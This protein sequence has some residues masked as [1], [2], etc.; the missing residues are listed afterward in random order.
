ML[1]T[2][3][4]AAALVLA[5]LLAVPLTGFSRADPEPTCTRDET[6][7]RCLVEAPPATTRTDP[8]QQVA[9]GGGPSGGSSA[10]QPCV[11]FMGEVKPCTDGDSWWSNELNCYISESTHDYPRSH[12]LWEG[13]TTGAIYDCYNPDIVSG[14]RMGTFWSQDPPAGPAAAPNPETLA[15]QALAAMNLRAP[16]IGIAP[17]DE[18]GSVGLVGLPVWMWVADPGDRTWGPTTASASAGG[19]TVTATATVGKV[20]W[21]MG[22]GTKVTC[23]TKG[24]AYTTSLGVRS[25]P[26]CGHQYSAMG[27]YTVT[28]TAYW[29]V[30][31]SGM[32]R[33]GEIA[34]DLE[35]STTVQIGE[36]QAVKN[37]Q[38]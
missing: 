10:P 15:R 35:R 28:A 8:P 19:H 33:T 38:G 1:T 4:R 5:V 23:T 16:R 26:D 17:K 14:M 13:N 36:A 32:G 18:P 12:P 27:E 20:V 25:S 31:W 24:T 7:G 11:N 37:T 2:H 29:T 34:L 6:T 3:A 9:A 22:D 21:T 30:A